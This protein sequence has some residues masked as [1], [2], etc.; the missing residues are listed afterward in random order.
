MRRSPARTSALTSS[1]FPSS[2]IGLASF[3]RPSRGDTSYT[4]TSV[5]RCSSI[6][7]PSLRPR[8][9]PGVSAVEQAHLPL[10]GV[11]DERDRVIAAEAGVAERIGAERLAGDGQRAP[12]AATG[13]ARARRD[14]GFLHVLE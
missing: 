5:G 7:S 1:I 9:R 10:P 13:G 4:L 14:D 8:R 6:G 3:W 2:G 12:S 11:W